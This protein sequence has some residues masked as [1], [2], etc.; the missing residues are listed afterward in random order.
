MRWCAGLWTFW[1][2]FPE[3]KAWYQ[4]RSCHACGS[5]RSVSS[6]GVQHAGLLACPCCYVTFADSRLHPVTTEDCYVEHVREC[7]ETFPEPRLRRSVRARW[8]K[9]F[10]VDVMTAPTLTLRSFVSR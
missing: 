8:F 10:R 1:S 6:C 9:D 5:C 2:P 4:C 3:T 7:P